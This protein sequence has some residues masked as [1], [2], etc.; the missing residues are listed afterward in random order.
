MGAAWQVTLA[1]SRGSMLTD[2]MLRRMLADRFRLVIAIAALIALAWSPA[3]AAQPDDAR[4]QEALRTWYRLVLELVRHTPTYSPPVASR[5]LAYL[6]VTAFEAVAEGSG[7]L[8]SFAGQLNGLQSLPQ[9]EAGPLR[10][11]GQQRGLEVH[12]PGDAGEA[13]RPV[14]HRIHAGHHCQQHLG[15]ADI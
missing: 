11:I 14:P 12:P 13:L 6:G 10:R 2:G 8:R 5:S 9:R 4:A 7:E 3:T 1:D 15:C